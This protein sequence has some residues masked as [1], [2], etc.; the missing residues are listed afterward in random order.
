MKSI[1]RNARIITAGDC[2]PTASATAPIVAARLYAGAV[3]ATPITT[4]DI[5]PSAPPFSP[6]SPPGS[7][8]TPAGRRRGHAGRHRYLPVGRP[9]GVRGVTHP[10]RGPTPTAH[11]SSPT[12]E[13]AVRRT[14]PAPR[15]PQQGGTG[16]GGGG[17][18][19]RAD[20]RMILLS[21]ACSSTL[22]DQPITRATANVGV[23]IS[24]GSPHSAITTPA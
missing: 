16:W 9:P 5:R 22:A 8:V 19:Y 17:P 21:R 10:Q 3:E 18:T 20:G 11:A 2:R 15:R 7:S 23:N 24:R 14:A 12:N 6:L 4:L 1:G 13:P